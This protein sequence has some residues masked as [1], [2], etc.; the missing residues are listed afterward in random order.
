MWPSNDLALVVFLAI[1]NLIFT[2]LLGQMAWLVSGIPGSN[3]VFSIGYA[4]LIS[5]ALLVFEGRRWRFFTQSVLIIVLALPTYLNGP[6]FD[7]IIRLPVF[8]N[9]LHGDLLFNSPPESSCLSQRFLQ[10]SVP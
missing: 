8:L 3:M 4:I 1:L 2:A 5:F 6:P 10:P 9:A 7:V